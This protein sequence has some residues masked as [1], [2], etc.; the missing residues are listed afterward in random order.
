M[1]VKV[2]LKRLT[3]IALGGLVIIGF[4]MWIASF[5]AHV[6]IAKQLPAPPPAAGIGFEKIQKI[7]FII[8]ENLPAKP[9]MDSG[10]P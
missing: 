8:K 3:A 9:Q 1:S 2:N 7:I 4:G 6:A 5:R 10:F